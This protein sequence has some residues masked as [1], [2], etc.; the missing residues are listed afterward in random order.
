MTK[1]QSHYHT[2]K[3]TLTKRHNLLQRS[4]WTKHPEVITHLT[5][6]TKQLAVS[7]LG[8]LMIL[9]APVLPTTVSQ[10]VVPVK[11]NKTK[12]K[13]L[14]QET[15]LISDLHNILPDEIRPLSSGEEKT[16]IE[17]LKRHFNIPLH[18]ELQGKRLNRNYGLIGAEQ[19]LTRYPG[20]TMATHFK[21]PDNA[22][23]Y[24]SSGMAPGKGAWGYFAQ[25]KQEL[26]EEDIMREKY[27]IAAQTFLS[28][29]YNSRVAEY[30]DF[31][32]YRKVLVVNPQNARAVV[33]VIADAG[34]GKS[35]G[36][37][38]GG[39]PEVMKHL[40]RVDGKRKG[41]V[42][43]FFIDDP[44]NAVPLGPITPNEQTLL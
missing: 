28:K 13:K 5:D 32:K 22:A 15:F 37:H 9:S 41:A 19:H 42:L 16:I 6:R 39:S 18:A 14:N 1:K 44:E 20:D 11:E 33:A 3:K 26:T 40:K 17:T 10:S 12:I 23:K 24:Y 38:L 2:L 30:R 21:N 27:Y 35:T 36:K 31:F 7:S 4:L 8:S 34:P 43:Y 25:S 29:D